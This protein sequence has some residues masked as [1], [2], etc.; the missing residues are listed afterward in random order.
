M[1][2]IPGVFWLLRG[3]A[4]QALGSVSVSPTLCIL[5]MWQAVTCMSLRL[6]TP[7]ATRRARGHDVHSAALG[8]AQQRREM[9]ETSAGIPAGEVGS[10]DQ[11]AM[12]VRDL[13]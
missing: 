1:L 5:D 2:S 7:A 12:V 9:T 6:S 13:D 3:Y 4:H 10:I 8:N 11:V